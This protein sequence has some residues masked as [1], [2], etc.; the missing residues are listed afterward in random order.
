MSWFQGHLRSWGLAQLVACR[1]SGVNPGSRGRAGW[2]REW[3]HSVI[4]EVATQT[5]VPSSSWSGWRWKRDCGTV[6][7]GKVSGQAAVST[8]IIVIRGPRVWVSQP[9]PGLPTTTTLNTMTT[10]VKANCHCK[11][12]VFNIAFATNSLPISND[13]CHCS[14]CRHSTGQLMVEQVKFVGTPLSA[15][16]EPIDYSGLTAYK[17]STS[18]I[19]WFCKRCSAHILWSYTTTPEA[20]CVAVG[21]LERT[22]GIVGRAPGEAPTLNGYVRQDNVIFVAAGETGESKGATK[23]KERLI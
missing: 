16:N 7:V 4:E 9:A 5:C 2:Y 10:F 15:T 8:C 23:G 19:R 12:N 21:A 22:E 17:T 1:R 11:L 3:E 18:A 6:S 13:L 14:S 20:W